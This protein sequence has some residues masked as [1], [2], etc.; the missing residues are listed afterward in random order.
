MAG[1]TE[2]AGTRSAR[3]QPKFWSLANGEATVG[4][5]VSIS[6][7][8]TAQDTITRNGDYVR[9]WRVAGVPFDGVQDAIVQAHHE[10]LCNLL[11]NLPGDRAAVYQYRI[12]RRGSDRLRDPDPHLAPG[13]SAAFSRRYQD[14]ICAEPFLLKEFYLV[15]LWRPYES[16]RERIVYRNTRTAQTIRETQARHLAEFAEL[17]T[18]VEKTLED[19]D[20]HPLGIRH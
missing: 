20:L 1:D 12:Q 15:L 3:S 11:A 16:E 14:A 18:L 7:P 2:L 6:A 8:V 19:F 9:A 17:A 10:S 4:E 13:F 5:F